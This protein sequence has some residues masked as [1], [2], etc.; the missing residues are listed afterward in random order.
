MYSTTPNQQILEA[1][2]KLSE[3]QIQIVLQFIQSLQP[4]KIST[5]A[6]TPFNPLANFV[7]ATN[8]GNLAQKIDRELYE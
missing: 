6:C 8:L 1:I 2:G 3:Q 4:T 7:G 5:T